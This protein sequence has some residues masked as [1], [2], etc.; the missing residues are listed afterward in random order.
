MAKI[1]NV[2]DITNEDEMENN[3]LSSS[4]SS[5]TAKPTEKPKLNYLNRKIN[6]YI[7]NRTKIDQVKMVQQSAQF[8]T[9]D[10]FDQQ[11]KFWNEFGNMVSYN[12]GVSSRKTPNVPNVYK[13]SKQTAEDEVSLVEL[14]DIKNYINNSN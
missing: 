1:D 2:L 4:K 13:A 14:Q 7:F 9:E 8:N 12:R 6:L 5:P 10:S 11:S 3:N